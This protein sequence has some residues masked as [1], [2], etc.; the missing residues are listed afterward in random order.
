MCP[1]CNCRRLYVVNEVA[2][3]DHDSSN[4]ILPLTVTA[5]PYS[6]KALQLSEEHG[7]RYR[8]HAGSFEAWIC[9]QCGYTEWYARDPHRVLEVLARHG[10]GVRVVDGAAPATPFR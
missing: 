3:P 2:L 8:T 7:T 5:V 4:V 10:A 1:K 9:S 6:V